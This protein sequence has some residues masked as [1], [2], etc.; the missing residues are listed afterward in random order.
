MLYNETW[1][2]GLES[3]HKLRGENRYLP[4]ND[5]GRMMAAERL[6]KK[7]ADIHFDI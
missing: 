4:L 2:N 3:C 7:Y 5:E 1:K 6:G